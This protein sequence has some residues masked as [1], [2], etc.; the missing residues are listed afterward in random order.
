MIVGGDAICAAAGLREKEPST[1]CAA[2]LVAGRTNPQ[3]E[4]RAVAAPLDYG[5]RDSDF[6]LSVGGIRSL[7]VRI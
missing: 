2:G 3:H 4:K 5:R 6:D 7:E 1:T